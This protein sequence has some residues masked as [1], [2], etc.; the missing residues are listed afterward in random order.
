MC[1]HDFTFQSTYLTP[2]HFVYSNT[3]AEFKKQ[4]NLQYK[5]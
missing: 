5:R 2:R 1:L 3:G 4:G